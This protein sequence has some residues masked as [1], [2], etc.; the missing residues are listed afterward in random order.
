[1]NLSNQ[2]MEVDYSQTVDAL[3]AQIR[4]KQLETALSGLMR[5]SAE[6]AD[7]ARHLRTLREGRTHG[8]SAQVA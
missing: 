2:H 8:G 3:L 5:E 7:E 6:L 4:R 1:M